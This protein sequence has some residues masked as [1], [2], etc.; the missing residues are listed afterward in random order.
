MAG[1]DHMTD[2]KGTDEKITATLARLGVNLDTVDGRT[3]GHLRKVE[4]AIQGETEARRRAEEEVRRH[5]LSVSSVAKASGVSHATFYNKT[6][7]KRYVNARKEEEIPRTREGRD[8]SLERR[9]EEA[10]IEIGLMNEQGALMVQLQIENDRLKRRV[11]MLEVQLQGGQPAMDGKGE[12]L[13]FGR[14]MT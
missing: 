12:V 1:D 11:R 14:K 4:Q 3:M 9:L 10:R 5:N 8:A 2:N 13:P 6:L 7:L